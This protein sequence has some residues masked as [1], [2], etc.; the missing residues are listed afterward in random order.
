MCVLMFLH[1]RTHNVCSLFRA[2]ALLMMMHTQRLELS[3]AASQNSSNHVHL[4]LFSEVHSWLMSAV[5]GSMPC[6]YSKRACGSTLN[7]RVRVRVCVRARVLSL[8]HPYRC[9]GPS[10]S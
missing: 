8:Y 9:C 10:V 3:A 1:T 7:V 6:L 4:A 5:G 2:S